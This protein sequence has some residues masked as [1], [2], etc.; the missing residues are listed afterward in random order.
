MKYFSLI[1]L[2]NSIDVSL[3]FIFIISHGKFGVTVLSRASSSLV[4]VIMD[5]I[6]FIYS[7]S[8]RKEVFS[9]QKPRPLSRY[10]S[11]FAMRPVNDLYYNQGRCLYWLSCKMCI[12]LREKI[13]SAL[14]F[15]VL[16][17][18]CKSSLFRVL[19]SPSRQF[20]SF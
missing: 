1:Y 7:S 5:C 15:G 3:I 6:F 12:D 2:S 20:L 13:K 16:L 11:I 18:P 9:F 8:F 4:W 14:Y 10:T 17:S 19:Y